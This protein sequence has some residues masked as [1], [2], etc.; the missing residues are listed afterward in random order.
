ML[1]RLWLS[2]IKRETLASV[3]P[4]EKGLRIILASGLEFCIWDFYGKLRHDPCPV[5]TSKGYN[6]KDGL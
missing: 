1:H 2:H 4:L 5:K 6:K 3:P